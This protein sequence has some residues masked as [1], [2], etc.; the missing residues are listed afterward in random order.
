MRMRS[1]T[2]SNFENRDGGEDGRKME[3][4]EEALTCSG[5]GGGGDRQDV[6]DEEERSS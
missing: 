5:G 2:P 3:G 1:I 6:C 4:G